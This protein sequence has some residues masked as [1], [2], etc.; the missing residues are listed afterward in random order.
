MRVFQMCGAQQAI[1]HHWGTFQLT[2]EAIGAP[3][4]A[5]SAALEAANIAPDAFRAF[6]P[7]EVLE[8]RFG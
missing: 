1:G 7:G 3:A 8:T 2:D 6:H 4:R 5:L